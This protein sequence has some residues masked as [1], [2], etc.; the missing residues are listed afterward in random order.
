[1]TEDL[2][3]GLVVL[4]GLLLA[5][6][7]V[8]IVSKK[9][10]FPFTI[11]LVVI[12]LVLGWGSRNVAV[13]F[14]LTAFSLTPEVVLFIF[15]PVLIFES[16]FN[17]NARALLKNLLPILTLA[18]PGLLMATA[19]VGFLMHFVLDLPLGVSFLFGALISATDPVAVISL[20]KELGAPKRLTMLVEGESLFNDGTALVLFRVI[21]GVVLVGEFSGETLVHGLIEFLIVFIGGVGVGILLGLVFG[22]IIQIVEN[23]HLVEIT[24]T[25]ILALSA[26]MVAE[27]FLEV[28]G[29][30]ATVAAGLTMGSYGRTKIS[31]PV[32]REMEAF[33]EYFAFICNSLIFLLVG[34]SVDFALF[35]DNSGAIFFGAFAVVAG[36]AL[37]VYTLFPLIG[38]FKT[39]EKVNRAFQTIIFWGGLRGALAIVIALSIPSELEQKSFILTLTLGVVLLSL[40]IN[41]LTIR[42]VMSLVGLDKYTLKE[43]YERSQAIVSSLKEAVEKMESLASQG[44]IH[45]TLFI[46]RKQAYEKEITALKEELA[47]LTHGQTSLRYED[48]SEIILRHCLNSERSQYRTFFE[49][50]YLD[51]D[52]LKEMNHRIDLELDRVKTGQDITGLEEVPSLFNRLEDTFLKLMGGL[53]FLRPITRRFKTRRIAAGYEMERARYHVSAV[54]LEGIEEMEEQMTVSA[55]PLE[56]AKQFYQKLHGQ[57]EARVDTIR[58]EFPQYVEKVEAGILTRL[59]LNSELATFTELHSQ[60]AI[61]DKVLMEMSEDINSRLRR[62]QMRPVEE[63]LI[64]PPELL[65]MVPYFKE[66]KEIELMNL[67]SRLTALSFL[68]G[69]EIVKEGD[70]GD[71]L[72]IIGRG[73]VDVSTGGAGQ[74]THL[75]RLKAGDFFGE[76]ALLE[77]QPRIATV[78]AITP[79]TLLEL[80]RDRLLPYLEKAPELRDM[81]ESTTE[82]RILDTRR[83]RE[84]GK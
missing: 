49:E 36:R 53:F 59:C 68:P 13:L 55:Q 51:E 29:V 70:A 12:G 74:P 15:L 16:A 48:E 81:L 50:G 52:N 67:C 80:T 1:M 22:K 56:Q 23:D 17:L 31:P 38:R 41:G 65:R 37:V 78:T 32:H 62:M 44:A 40:F 10:K 35:V 19:A 26:F 3:F 57:A 42:N 60:G 27:H 25:V 54:L 39:V 63:L 75:A 79:C 5:A 64:P 46:S 28:S 34:L 20:F 18:I 73:Q 82:I 6:S 45:N 72:F 21:L 58:A 24:L 11:L 14:P 76:V 84:K 77:T 43:R 69:E 7:V 47:Q 83:A 71:S 4:M 8:A 9:I 61:S 33:W 30:M 66:L 2:V